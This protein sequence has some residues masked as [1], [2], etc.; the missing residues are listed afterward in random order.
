MSSDEQPYPPC[1][2]HS[3]R[4]RLGEGSRRSRWSGRREVPLFG[5]SRDNR[6]GARTDCLRC[7]HP[8]SYLISPALCFSLRSADTYSTEHRE[9]TLLIWAL[10]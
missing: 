2:G 8:P 7:P 6:F 1:S 3:Q 4:S 10:A 9:C 5:G